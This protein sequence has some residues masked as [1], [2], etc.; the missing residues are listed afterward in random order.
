M[1]RE[2]AA[3][4]IGGYFGTW[5]ARPD[6]AR[7]PMTTAG[8]ARRPGRRPGAGVLFALPAG[9]C[10]LTETARILA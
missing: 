3:L 8:P 6:V 9:S 5:H 10:G 4:L 1:R 2:P 7:L